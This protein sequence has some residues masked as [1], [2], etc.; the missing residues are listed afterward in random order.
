[1]SRTFQGFDR[2]TSDPGVLGGQPC[3]RGTRLTVSRVLEVVS[4]D[5]TRAEIRADYPRLDDEDIRQ[6]L[7]FAAHSLRDDRMIPLASDA[8]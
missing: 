6:A 7:A 8:A 4:Q 1:M 5:L 3:V 2:I